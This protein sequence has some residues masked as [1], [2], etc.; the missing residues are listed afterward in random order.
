MSDRIRVAV[1]DDHPLFRE[2][3]AHA[4]QNSELLEVVGEGATAVDAV[5]IAK[6]ALPDILLLDVSMPGGG[7][8]AARVIARVYPM[9]KT[10]MLTV[11]EHE[12]HVLQSLEAGARGYVVKGTSG[13]ELINT[14]CAVSR[15]EA[16]VTPRLAARLL[17]LSKRRPPLMP[18]PNH[19]LPELTGREKQIVDYVA[20]GQT[21]K[22]IARGLTIS[23]KTVKHYM[24]IIMQKL[25]ARNRVE[26]VLALQRQGQ[27][28]GPTDLPSHP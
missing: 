17:T 7:I 20:R 24:T 16:Y 11:S 25:H 10:V 1:V 12:E 8:D 27:N 28:G 3:V 18:A 9:V 6:D 23:E 5:R 4:I 15:G 26:A 22:E 21:N 13:V 14:L 2:G 19:Q